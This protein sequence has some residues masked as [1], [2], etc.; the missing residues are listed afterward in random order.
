MVLGEKAKY[1]IKFKNPLA[2]EVHNIVLNIDVDG[3]SECE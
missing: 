3:M 1:L 2:V